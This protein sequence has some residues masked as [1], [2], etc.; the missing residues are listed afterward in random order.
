MNG[1]LHAWSAH[2]V[3]V[4]EADNGEVRDADGVEVGRV[5]T[6]DL[7]SGECVIQDHTG[8]IRNKTYA[9]PMIFK[10]FGTTT[11]GRRHD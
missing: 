10:R 5:L 1:I 9:A 3:S 6:A 7:R 2:L 11:K 8:T 4:Y